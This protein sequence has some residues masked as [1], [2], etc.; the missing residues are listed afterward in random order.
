VRWAP[1]WESDTEKYVYEAAK[2]KVKEEMGLGDFV[3]FSKVPLSEIIQRISAEACKKMGIKWR[4]LRMSMEE[5]SGRGSPA[6]VGNHAYPEDV[7]G[8]AV[9]AGVPE[10]A[11][12]P[13]PAGE[14]G[15]GGEAVG[16]DVDDRCPF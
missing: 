12:D 5:A 10:G 3:D 1:L 4:P 13:E 14:R 11:A 15:A 16:D 7:G 6:G 9:E 8:G 2:D